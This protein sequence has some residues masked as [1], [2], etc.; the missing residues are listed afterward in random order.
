LSHLWIANEAGLF[1]KYSVEVVPVYFNGGRPLLQALIANDIQFGVTSG[2]T[3]ARAIIAGADAIIV[4]GHLNRLTYTL[5]TSKDIAKPE[6]LRGKAMAIS[7]FG[8]TSHAS[9]ILALRKLGV[10]LK[11]V[12]LVQ[13]G[14][15]SSRFAALHAGSVQGVAIAPP[16]TLLAKQQGFNPMLDLTQ[17]EI[18]WSQELVLANG[19]VLKKEPVLAKNFMKGFIDGLRLWH[20]DKAK[21]TELLA[22]FMK[23]D[24][25]TNR[26]ALEEAYDF[27]RRATEKKP[28]PSLDGLRVQLDMIA[29]TDPR[30]KRANPEQLV[31][32]RI[33][34]ELDKSG[35]IDGLYKQPALSAGTTPRN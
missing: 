29:E 35:F 22:K 24:A 27:M 7:G 31:D 9:T 12:T 4:A 34:Q 3:S 10:P 28:Y 17:A 6:Q 32:L 18:P 20:T 1:K 16:L 15:Q 13:I 25:K 30:A 5:F 26:E 8:T 23:I 21:T 2:I 14:D 19:A 33:I 11:D